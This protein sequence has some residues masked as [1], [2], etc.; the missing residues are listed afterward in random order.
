MTQRAVSKGFNRDEAVERL[1]QGFKA[2]RGDNLVTY[3]VY[4]G[5]ATEKKAEAIAAEYD[6]YQASM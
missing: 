4:W 5:F 2:H 1:F 3:L 6:A